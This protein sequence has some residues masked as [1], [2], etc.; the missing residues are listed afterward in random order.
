[1]AENGTGTPERGSSHTEPRLR[2]GSHAR[3]DVYP[4]NMYPQTRASYPPAST[5]PRAVTP[6]YPPASTRPRAVTPSYPRTGGASRVNGVSGV[7]GVSRVNGASRNDPRR[8]ADAAYPHADARRAAD[9][10]YNTAEAVPEAAPERDAYGK[11]A[12]PVSRPEGHFQDALFP[13]EEDRRP[14]RRLAALLALPCLAAYAGSFILLNAPL[15]L[16][17]A[18]LPH[19]LGDSFRVLLPSLMGTLGCGALWPLF[20]KDRRVMAAVHGRLLMFLLAIF[21][22][23]QLLL[24]GEQETQILILH[25]FIRFLFLPVLIGGA[26]SVLL[27]YRHWRRGGQLRN[28]N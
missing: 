26:V 17:T 5:R 28:P 14:L 27:C 12:H 11:T 7:D 8:A 4:Q 13:E 24:W 21:A 18:Q 2:H 19:F 10:F 16:L 1:M 25:F 15:N 9:P 23:L 22:A 20:P 6:S 3:P